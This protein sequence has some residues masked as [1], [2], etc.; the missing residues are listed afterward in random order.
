MDFYAWG[1]TGM[2]A[3]P[4][5]PFGPMQYVRASDHDTE[6]RKVREQRDALYQFARHKSECSSFNPRRRC[7][8]GLDAALAWRTPREIGL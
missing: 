4:E 6:L 3:E 8:C 7:D 5:K 1:A 2:R